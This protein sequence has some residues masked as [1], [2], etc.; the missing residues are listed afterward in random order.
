MLSLPALGTRLQT[1]VVQ[2]TIRTVVRSAQHRMI[3]AFYWGVACAIA[4]VFVKSPR[5]QQ[6]A[7]VPGAAHGSKRACRS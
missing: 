1:A 2:F 5:G 4:I 7:E 6:F 3:L